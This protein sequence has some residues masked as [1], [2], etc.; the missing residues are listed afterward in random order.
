[1]SHDYIYLFI[2]IKKCINFAYFVINVLQIDLCVL[3]N[4]FFMFYINFDF[5]YKVELILP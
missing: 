1:M 2:R 4:V 3:A 5:D